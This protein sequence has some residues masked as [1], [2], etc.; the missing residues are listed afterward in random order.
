M[1]RH[2][3]ACAETSGDWGLDSAYTSA[4]CCGEIGELRFTVIAN[5]R[6]PEEV[7]AHIFAAEIL[8]WSACAIAIATVLGFS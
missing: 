2:E 1:D 5:L 7:F 6:S 4:Q 3:T 8:H